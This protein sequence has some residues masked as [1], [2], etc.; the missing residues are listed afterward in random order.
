[1]NHFFIGIHLLVPFNQLNLP[2]QNLS[3]MGDLTMYT[4]II[5][6]RVELQLP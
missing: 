6:K 2:P 3:F 5:L 4:K 1:M